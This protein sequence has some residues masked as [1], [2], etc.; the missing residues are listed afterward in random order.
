MTAAAI[1][2]ATASMADPRPAPSTPPASVPPAAPP[3]SAAR[4]AFVYMGGTLASRVSG[5]LREVLLVALF[6][7]RASDAFRIAWAVPNLFRELLAEGA[8]TNAFVPVVQ[9]LRGDDRRAF[10]GAMLTALTVA[11]A[12]LLGAAILAAPWIVDLLLAADANVDRDLAVRLLRLTFPVLMAISLSALAMGVLQAEERFLAPAWA[13]VALN[14]A[15]IVAM[16]AFPGVPEALAWGVVAGGLLQALVQAPALARAGLLPRWR[17]WHAAMPAALALM[18]PFAFTTGARQVLNVVAQRLVSNEDLFPAGA[19]TGY[20]IASMLFS[21]LLGLFAISPA[22]AFYARLGRRA[23]EDDG[24]GFRAALEEG[25][26]FIATLTVPA[27]VAV[28]LFAE[29][30]VRVLFEVLRPAAGQERAIALAVAALAPLGVGLTASG[31]VNFLLRPFFVRGRVR[32]PVALAVA[33]SALTA[34][35][36][37]VLT[38]RLGIAGLSWATAVAQGALAA[39]LVGWHART[40]AWSPAPLLFDLGRVVLAAVA[41]GAAAW[42]VTAPFTGGVEA[43]WARHALVL[44]VGG[45]TLGGVYAALGALLGARDVRALLRRLRRT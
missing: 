44:V 5:L 31:W 43:G 24:P 10:A 45:V 3:R 16:L 25:A 39:V 29:P 21:L 2:A 38:P 17:W 42:A 28:V 9:R 4:G 41:A 20:A 33:T 13:P 36:F 34:V 37:V 35:L 40:E 6:P 8:L 19:V 1:V 18:A 22:V 32:A 26:R 27:G 14:V 7:V 15:A 30:A 23:A 12:L 11:N